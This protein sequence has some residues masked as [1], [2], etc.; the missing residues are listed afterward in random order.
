MINVTRSSME[1]WENSD[2]SKALWRARWIDRTDSLKVNEPMRLGLFFEQE[3]IGASAYDDSRVSLEDLPKGRGASMSVKVERVLNQIE[4]CKS[5]FNKDSDK[6]LGYEIDKV[7][8]VLEYVNN[9]LGYKEK[10]IRDIVA[11]DSNGRKVIIDLKLTGDAESTFHAKGWGHNENSDFTQG[12][13]YL[14]TSEKVDENIDEFIYLIFDYT[15]NERVKKISVKLNEEKRDR[16]QSRKM[17][18]LKEVKE[19]LELPIILQQ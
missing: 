17:N 12:Y 16:I 10:N 9:D 2:I 4:L 1:D 14:D 7:Q 15:K 13:F 5:I 8:H 3:A 11:V 19:F 18:F 6:F